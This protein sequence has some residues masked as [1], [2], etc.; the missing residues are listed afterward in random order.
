MPV[1]T[2]TLK[3]NTFIALDDVK[4]WLKIPLANTDHDNRLKRL[5]NL[6]TDEAERYISG[7]IK[8]QTYV[9][10]RDGD[11]S[12]TIVPDYWPL[13]SITELKVD[14]N[15]GFG[16]E[17]IIIPADYFA[18]GPKNVSSVG[19]N[20]TDIVVRGDSNSTA[21]L[22]SLIVGSVVGCI[23][24][25]YVAGHGAD[26]TEIPFSFQ[27]AVLLLVEHYYLVRENREL[28]IKSKTNNNQGYSREL[29]I[30]KEV[31]DLLDPYVDYAIPH[32]NKPQSNRSG[33]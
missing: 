32:I 5:I 3:S 29:G 31:T 15:R 18:R 28:N 2:I 22:G 17:S 23:K 9:E 7:P 26:A 24:L 16:T 30:P 6:A 20:G 13:K 4:D 8:N 10:E 25:T 27:Q 14:Y 1:T 12:D 19:I 21:T 11:S 33:L